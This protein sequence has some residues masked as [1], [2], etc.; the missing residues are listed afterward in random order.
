[1]REEQNSTVP[2]CTHEFTNFAEEK[3]GRKKWKLFCP[4]ANSKTSRN[5]QV[6]MVGNKNGLSTREAIDTIP[7]FC[8]E[9]F[10][11]HL[12]TGKNL[13]LQNFISIVAFAC[14]NGK[15]NFYFIMTF[16]SVELGIH[17][18]AILSL[19]LGFPLQC[20]SMTL[21]VRAAGSVR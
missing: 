3:Y 4:R 9:S 5:T 16:R 1:M 19:V 8:S 14:K 17:P 15:G 6:S 2:I 12:Q 20:T 11:V 7:K 21:R 10:W 13:Q 18:A